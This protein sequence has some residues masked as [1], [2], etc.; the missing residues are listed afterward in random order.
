[1]EKMDGATKLAFGINLYNLMI[2]H[3][4]IKVGIAN[5]VFARTFHFFDDVRYNI[6][7]HSISFMKLENGILRGN[8]YVRYINSIPCCK[9]NN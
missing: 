1:M 7:G 8:R 6:G 2:K 4:F 3:A 5:T 9:D